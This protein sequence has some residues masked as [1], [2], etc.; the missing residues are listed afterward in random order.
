LIIQQQADDAGFYPLMEKDYYWF[1]PKAQ[2]WMCGNLFG[3]FDH[4]IESTSV[5]FGRSLRTDQWQVI[6]RRV[7]ADPAFPKKSM[8]NQPRESSDE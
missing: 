1:D 7:L 4:L 8:V 2:E 3:L 6:K 5:K